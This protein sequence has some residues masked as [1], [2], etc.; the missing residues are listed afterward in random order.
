MGSKPASPCLREKPEGDSRSGRL[1]LSRAFHLHL[2]PTSLQQAGMSQMPRIPGAWAPARAA[3]RCEYFLGSDARCSG[4]MF[5]FLFLFFC[6]LF[7]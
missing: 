6:F 2:R 3:G 1:H 7:I 4:R 5:P